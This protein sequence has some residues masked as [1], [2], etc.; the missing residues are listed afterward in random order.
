MASI[1]SGVGPA[2][3]D[4]IAERLREFA[5][6][7][8]ELSLYGAICSAAAEDPDIVELLLAARPGQGRPVLLLAAIHDLVLDLAEQGR[9]PPVARWYA[10]VVGR[11]NLPGP[12]EWS[13]PGPW[14]QVREFALAHRAE[15]TATIAT[16]ST[17]TNE[18]NRS[19][20]VMTLLAEAS[21]GKPVG[22]V[23]FGAS[24][25]LLLTPDHY[26][27]QLT[28]D[29]EAPVQRW[30]DAHSAVHASGV[31]RGRVPARD[32]SVLSRVGVDLDPIGPEELSRLRWL[33]ACLWPD[34]PGR[35]ERFRAAVDQRR[36][37]DARHRPIMLRGDFTDPAV[38]RQALATAAE[39]GVPQVVAVTSWAITYVERSQ[40]ESFARSLAQY[41]REIPVWWCSAE[42]TGA[43]P[44]LPADSA[45]EPGG[46]QLGLRRW[47]GGRELAPVSLG[48]A[49]PHGRWVNL[50]SRGD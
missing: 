29:D 32:V 45:L 6:A 44:G 24:A 1:D 50:T 20:Y 18:V 48:A 8:P 10:S 39:A 22:L 7:F 40:R 33:Q 46:T 12:D 3:R 37:L 43:V 4:R 49:D 25:G 28:E 15:L 38:V 30:G 23:E 47:Q 19:T 17:Q 2:R 9:P 36:A 14:P 11:E 41:S 5:A 27:V 42:P 34:V 26:D 13:R 35:I 21:H 31:C 16:S